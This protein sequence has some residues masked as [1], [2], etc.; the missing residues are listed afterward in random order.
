M[1]KVRPQ[2]ED[3][4][5]KYRTTPKAFVSLATAKRLWASRWGTISLLRVPHGR[6]FCGRVPKRKQ[7]LAKYL[8]PAALGM[9]F[10]PVKRL[11]LAASS[12]TT[13]F[14]GLFLGFS[15]FLIAAAVMLISLLFKLGVEQRAQELGILAATG[16]ERKQ[17]TWLLSREGLIVAAIG[18][19]VG[20]V[21]GVLYAWLV[22]MGLCTWW[23]AAVATPFLRLH[24][25]RESLVIGWL[26]GVL[27][28]WITIRLSIRR[29]VR[30]PA[31][32]IAG[33]ARTGTDVMQSRTISAASSWPRFREALVAL[34]VALAVLGYVLQGEA[35]AGIFFASG[36]AVLVL[37]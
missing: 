35:Q 12:G 23:V 18:A 37:L 7:Q 5:D 32:Q 16:F 25:T 11:G 24:V 28:S 36:A 1:E 19:A 30:L 14:D 27:V 15:F 33:R 2:D 3:Y 17:I 22:I 20:A 6:A 9:K 26:I 31:G 29:L 4:W 8:E 21:V 34:A 10:L 13:P